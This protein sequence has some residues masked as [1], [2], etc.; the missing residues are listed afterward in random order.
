MEAL[1]RVLVRRF[2]ADEW[3]AYRGLRLRALAD[4]PDA[5]GSTL[6]LEGA[7]PDEHWAERLSVAARSP[8]QL[9]LVAELGAEHV[10]LAWGMIAPAAPEIAQVF[11]MWVAH[12]AR[13]RGCATLLLETVLAWARAASATSVRLA[14]TCGDT[15]ARRLYER[16]GFTPLGDLEPLRPDSSVRVQPMTLTL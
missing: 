3:P 10:G 16:A 7:K 4:T 2:R 5:F 8:S 1:P 14:V 6:E 11:Q 15:P 12:P 13:G 9:P